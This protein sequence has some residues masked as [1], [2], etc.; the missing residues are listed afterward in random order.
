MRSPESTRQAGAAAGLGEGES[1][2]ITDVGGDQTL[3]C[4]RRETEQRADHEVVLLQNRETSFLG[5]SHCGMLVLSP[6]C[7]VRSPL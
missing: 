4:Q 1:A 7:A 2:V 3:L 5:A 6:M